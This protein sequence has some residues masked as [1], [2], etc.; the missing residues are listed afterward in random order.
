MVDIRASLSAALDAGVLTVGEETTLVNTQKSRWFMERHLLDS[1]EDARQL[2]VMD[3]ERIKILDIFLRTNRVSV[4]AQDARSAIAALRELPDG[5]MPVETRP[6]LPYSRVYDATTSRDVLVEAETGDRVSLDK[7]RRFFTLTDER[8][9]DIWKSVRDRSATHRLMSGFG[10][11]LT[12]EDFSKA[13]EAIAADLNVA[14]G[15]LIEKCLSM[16]MTE[17]QVQAWIREEAYVLRA[18][19]WMGGHSIYTLMTTEFLNQL[20][21]MGE[22]E[23]N[24]RGAAFQEKMME[25]SPHRHSQL[26]L[27]GAMNAYQQL[28]HWTPPEDL[29][30]YLSENNLGSRAEF[31]ERLM[32]GVAAG[33]E[34]FG[35]PLIE[36]NDEDSIDHTLAP[37]N[38]RGG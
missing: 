36:V 9:T 1:I 30:A 26:G 33:M 15:V 6:E 20:R 7:I 21:R 27:I 18:R 22:Y 38:S 4:K 28:A 29:D 10:V 2:M 16:D 31:Y 12:P 24:R 34:L 25:S 3:P 14:P 19:A 8:T 17:V 23:H 13:R 37:K 35:L 32:A 5:P 11:E